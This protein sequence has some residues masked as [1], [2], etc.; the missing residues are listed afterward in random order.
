MF[1]HHDELMAQTSARLRLPWAQLC[2]GFAEAGLTLTDGGRVKPETARKTWQRVRKEKGRLRQ[3]EAEA[4]AGQALRRAQD[5]QRH[6]PS[7]ISGRYEPP[8]ADPRQRVVVEAPPRPEPRPMVNL[9]A[10]AGESGADL[11]AEPE[12]VVMFEGDPLDLNLFVRPNVVE[13]WQKHDLDPQAQRRVKVAM[14]NLRFENWKKDRVMDPNNPID[15]ER[16]R[17]RV[18]RKV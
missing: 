11:L 8:L 1:D 5:P 7:R 15:R 12:L 3:L 2:V 6:S 17:R 10:V 14:L 13:P 9:P 16:K 18:L 4:E